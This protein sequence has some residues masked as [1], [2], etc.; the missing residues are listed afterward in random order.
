M[1]LQRSKHA[2]SKGRGLR[3]I[4]SIAE[5]AASLSTAMICGWFKSIFGLIDHIGGI[6][7][8]GVYELS[9]GALAYCFEGIRED[10]IRTRHDEA[11]FPYF[12]GVIWIG[13]FTKL[14]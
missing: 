1:C 10:Q 12:S 14:I 8:V 2:F 13:A 4:R 11:E 6:L 9:F 7:Q 5:P 3:E